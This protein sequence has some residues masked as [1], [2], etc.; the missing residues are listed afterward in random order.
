MNGRLLRSQFTY[1]SLLKK[2]LAQGASPT[3]FDS[4][5][6]DCPNIAP[7]GS[8]QNFTC[9]QRPDPLNRWGE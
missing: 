8:I 3:W 5:F 4:S 7:T 9:Q 6:F 1:G 2:R